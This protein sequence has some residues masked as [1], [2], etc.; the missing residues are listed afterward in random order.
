PRW[1]VDA[2]MTLEK[3]EGGK[4]WE[5]IL[6]MWWKQEAKAGFEGPARGHTS[7]RPVQVK[8]WIGVAR[9]GNVKPPIKDARAFGEEWWDWYL[10]MSPGWRERLTTGRLERGDGEGW[11]ELEFTG[12]SGMLNVLV[13]LCW[14]KDVLGSGDDAGWLEALEDVAWV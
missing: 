10:L 2:R 13:C 3:G 9:R 4:L 11:D 7:G 5:T 8:N 14:W 6:E 12:P 1:A